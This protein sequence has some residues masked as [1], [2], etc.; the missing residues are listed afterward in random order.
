M[1]LL[2]PG[3]EEEEDEVEA[4]GGCGGGRADGEDALGR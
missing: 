1:R 3:R 4:A 2:G